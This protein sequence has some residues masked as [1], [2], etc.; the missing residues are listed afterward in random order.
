MA[1]GTLGHVALLPIRPP[2]A[3]AIIDGRKTVEFRKVKFQRVVTHIVV[4]AS[5]PVQ[6]IIG[7]FEIAGI[8]Q[9][10]PESLWRKYRTVGAIRERE[11]RDY[12]AG[13]RSAVAINV[14]CVRALERPV[15]LRRLWA[16]RVPPQSFAYL[17]EDA[18][19][20]LEDLSGRG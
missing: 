4:Y 1:T 15:P 20:R 6:K 2:F 11:Y 10:T 12:Y 9:G 18:L 3:Q 5:S 17:K 14:G 16:S 13:T 19:S 7:Y 8:D